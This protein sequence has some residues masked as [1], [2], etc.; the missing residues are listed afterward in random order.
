[1]IGVKNAVKTAFDLF[2][3]LYDTKKFED[4]LLEEVEL[5][6]DKSTWLVTLGFYRQMPSVNIME[7]LGSKKY[8]RTYKTLQIDAETGEMIAMKSCGRETD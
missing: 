7:S 5:S 2:K 3:E 6:A 4:L 1:M 8:I